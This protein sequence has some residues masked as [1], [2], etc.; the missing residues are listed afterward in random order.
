VVG[1]VLFFSRLP[2]YLLLQTPHQLR[3]RYTERVRKPLDR[4]QFWL[5]LPVLQVGQEHAT[6]AGFNGQLNQ[7]PTALLAQLAYSLPEL[8]LNVICH[9]LSMNVLFTLRVAYTL[10]ESIMDTAHINDGADET[11]A[12]IYEAMAVINRAFEQITTALCKLESKG[13]LAEDYAYS[14]E[15]PIREIAARINCYVLA[16]VNERELDDRN[17]YSR[18]RVSAEK[19]RKS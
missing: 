19:R 16:K 3:N 12:E 14:Q 10:H 2:E 11:K 6:P 4:S 15:L 9:P 18:M 7:F 17:H 13:V 8:P 1:I 5:V